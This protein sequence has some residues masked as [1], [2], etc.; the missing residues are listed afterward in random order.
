[1][2]ECVAFLEARDGKKMSGLIAH[3][4]EGYDLSV[5]TKSASLLTWQ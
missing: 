4:Y 2:R 5:T 3:K 1:M